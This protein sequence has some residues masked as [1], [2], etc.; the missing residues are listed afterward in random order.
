MG[1]SK[2]TVSVPPDGVLMWMDSSYSGPLK[3]DR[4]KMSA[5]VPSVKQNLRLIHAFVT[6]THFAS[7]T[8]LSK[9]SIKGTCTIELLEPG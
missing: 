9:F 7:K 5:T 6:Y 3:G 8:D 4:G 2:G 1:C